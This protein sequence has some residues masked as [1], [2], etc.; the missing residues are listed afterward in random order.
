MTRIFIL[1]TLLALN[2][3]A[4]AAGELSLYILKDGK[5]LATQDILIY[6]LSEAQSDAGTTFATDAQGYLSAALPGGE[7]QVQLVA[8]E[9]GV[10]Q[11][12]VKK[13]FVITADRQTQIIL[14]L[15]SDN[16]LQFAD[17]EAAET[18][19]DNAT[20]AA[21]NREKGAVALTLLSAEDGKPVP[22]ARIFVAG[23]RTDA[24]TDEKGQV[25]LDIPEGNRTISIIHTAFSSQNIHVTVLPREMISKTVELSPAAMEL[26]EFVV[27]A[28]HVEGSVA[29]VI[30][31]ERN[32][33]AVGN[34]MGAEQFKKSGD[35][36]AASALKRASGL[37]IVGG[38]YVYVRG[39]GD[40]YSSILFNHLNIPSPNPTK[41]VVPLDIFPTAAIK[42]ITIQKSYTADLP[43]NF[44]GGT[45]LID[46]IDIPKEEG[47][48]KASVRVKYNKSTGKKVNQNPDPRV[49]M[50][51]SV[52]RASNDGNTIYS[53]PKYNIDPEYAQDIA[54][55][56]S[57][58][59]KEGTLPPGYKLSLAGGKSFEM[60][61]GLRL[62]VTGSVFYQND[63][64]SNDVSYDKYLYVPASQKYSLSQMVRREVTSFDE[65]YGGLISIGADYKEDNKFKYTFFNIYQNN[66]ITTTGMT[67]SIGD[68]T[69]YDL[70][71]YESYEKSLM[72]HQFNG[73]HHLHFGDGTEGYFDDMIVAWAY[74]TGE[75]ARKEPGSIEYQY[76]YLYQAPTLNKKVWYYYGD[77]K[78]KITNLRAD[79]TIPF[80]LNGRNNYTKAGY[81][82]YDK[83]RDFDN[84]RFKIQH[85][86]QN[87]DP[88][89]EQPIDDIL[90]SSNIDHWTFT[91]NYRQADA[92]KATQ[93]VTAY[94]LSQLLSVASSVDL[95]AGVRSETSKQQLVD[96]STGEPYKPLS[97]DDWFPSLGL[98]YRMTDDMQWR[99]GYSRTITRPDFREFS[100]NRYKD[101]VT[102]D[103]VFGYEGLKPTYIN[104]VDLKYEW[105]L[106]AGE[107]FSFA[108]FGKEFTD[109]IETVQ[110]LDTQSDTQNY[111]VSYR[112]AKSATS[113]GFELDLRK[114]FGFISESLEELL[115]VTNFSYINSQ[116]K[117]QEI[118]NDYFLGHLTSTKRSMMGQ[119][120]YVVNVILGYD[121]I[122]TG[123][124]ALFLFNQIGER[125][126]ALGT[127]DYA[128]S[129]EQPFA[130]LDFVTKWNLNNNHKK[131][132]D[133][134]Y[135]VKFKATNLLDSEQKITQ[136]G[137]KT[138]YYKPGSEYSLTLSVQ[139]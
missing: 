37:T 80:M 89:L 50:P 44:G 68:A 31:Q 95:I 24:V 59:R 51:G 4:A 49:E 81:F 43:G 72:L 84:R 109:P 61:N 16:T 75:A 32:S 99:M 65:E 22:G 131:T 25:V 64:D 94:Y 67:T 63:N 126:V 13:N 133:L 60:D 27:L 107:L 6:P 121:S 66:D 20:K 116:V 124:S 2:L 105:Y 54:S 135:A 56:R 138:L 39:L 114:R 17:T 10:A 125:L 1:V 48:I 115:F 40:R 117:I 38:K 129:Y 57:Y 34:V 82:D 97:T 46:S 100:P 23:L 11:A 53:Q 136:D 69:P 101:P 76:D 21:Q 137:H 128:D 71:Y 9:N 3:F 79:L 73:E 139:Y 123:N 47:F 5:P 41:R 127:Y 132:S 118:P 83:K 70:T 119:S 74:E 93:K 122:E 52:L 19:E 96:A 77:L 45:I 85:D 111:L 92:Y 18:V 113:Y 78:D 15:K 42:N 30:A 102:G 86:Y 90:N 28:P 91:S 103:I 35:D 98:T 120:P 33:D 110:A 106:S 36:N 87:N 26:E 8:K 29:S 88:E 12:Y 14:S 108:I 62:G 130:K 58:N 112:N 7:Y 134:T 104:N 55:Y